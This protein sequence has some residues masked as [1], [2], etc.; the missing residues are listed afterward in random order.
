MTHER[1][2]SIECGLARVIATLVAALCVGPCFVARAQAG[3]GERAESVQS[4]YAAL[5]GT[6]HTVTP[7]TAYDLHEITT[8]DGARLH[9]YVSR[10][11]TVF[12]VAWSSRAKPDLSVLLA[13]HYGEYATAAAAH[14]GNHKVFTMAKD[15]L[16]MSLMRLPRGFAGSAHVTALLPQG[17]TA[18]DIR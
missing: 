6:A 8:A 3:L 16:V 9:E 15:G 1:F 2:A 13:K 5:H 12:G 17:V 18:Q 14:H 11:G 7:L 4:D 10:S